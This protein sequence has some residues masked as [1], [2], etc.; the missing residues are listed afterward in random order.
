MRFYPKKFF[1]QLLTGVFLFCFGNSSF[2]QDKISQEKINLYTTIGIP[3][4]IN[5]G[6]RYQFEQV[7]AGAGFFV[8]PGDNGTSYFIS[9]EVLFHL[10]GE[11]KLSN[12]QPWYFKTGVTYHHFE[13]EH[14]TEK[15]TF[16]DTRIGR[17]INIS[18][19]V[20]FSIGLGFAFLLSYQ[21]EIEKPSDN[22]W[23]IIDASDISIWP[24]VGLTVFYRL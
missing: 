2:G 19:K 15:W 24:S 7:Q 11:S 14:A 12:R 18:N 6:A 5:L 20:G 21:E 13:S 3:E 8:F 9:A 4:I 16:L 1:F 10:L 23:G 17:D 22:G